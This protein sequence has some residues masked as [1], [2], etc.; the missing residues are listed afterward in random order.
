MS[1]ISLSKKKKKVV[2]V[3]YW[4]LCFSPPKKKKK[5]KKKKKEEVKSYIRFRRWIPYQKS[6]AFYGYLYVVLF[7][8]KPFL[9]WGV[10]AVTPRA[11]FTRA[12][13]NQLSI[14]PHLNACIKLAFKSSPYSLRFGV[15]CKCYSWVVGC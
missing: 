5:K 3:K 8:W 10:W 13:W 1:F 11:A 15:Y 12:I 2:L 7:L 9:R 4:N 14:V 6:N